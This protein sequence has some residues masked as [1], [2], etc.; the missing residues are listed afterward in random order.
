[1]MPGDPFEIMFAAAQGKIQP[2][3]MAVLK[4]QFGFVAGP[5]HVQFWDYIKGIFSGDLGPSLTYY[6]T[7]VTEIISGALPWTVFLAGTATLI[8]FLI[9]V[10]LGVFAA[11]NRGGK[12]D[13]MGAPSAALI[14]SFPQMVTAMLILFAFGVILNW[15]PV[16]Y[17]YNPD[18]DAGWTLEFFMS[19]AYHAAL[20]LITMV[21]TGIGGWLFLM[22]NSMINTLGEDYITMG[23]AKGLSSRR[24]MVNY[25][26]RN[27]SLPVVTAVAMALSFVVAGALLIEMIFNYPGLGN[28]MLGAVANRDYPLL[29]GLLL[30]IV[31]C[32][33]TANF[34]ADLA[35]LWLDPRLR[36]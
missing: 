22:R 27:A 16:G 33:L 11:Y 26:A 29:Q 4:E 15:F 34:L 23:K 32:V 9:G 3:Q 35:Y 2:E 7:P 14:G 17:G 19:V 8:S 25:A 13:S 36:K 6:P 18:I 1:M 21:I 20:P 28:E 30:I 24:V 5:W 10:S 31:V 12:L